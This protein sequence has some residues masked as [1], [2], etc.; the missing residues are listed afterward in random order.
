[1]E[2]KRFLA[3]GIISSLLIIGGCTKT[4]PGKE[5]LE[6][7]AFELDQIA[8]KKF[9]EKD[10][11]GMM[12]TTWNSSDLIV[13]DVG[14]VFHGFDDWKKVNADFMRKRPEARLEYSNIKNVANGDLVFGSRKF[15]IRYEDK[16]QNKVFAGSMI[17]VKSYKDGKLVVISLAIYGKD[18]PIE[19]IE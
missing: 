15:K 17:D 16:G 7:M 3:F 14:E 6:K 5:Q 13:L 18:E 2:I 8:A 10:I 9:N 4:T 11:D 19:K 12:A 1:M